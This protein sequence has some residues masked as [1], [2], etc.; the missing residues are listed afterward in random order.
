MGSGSSNNLDNKR[1][2]DLSLPYKGIGY[3][4][5]SGNLIWIQ[6][7]S[8]VAFASFRLLIP[9]KLTKPWQPTTTHQVSIL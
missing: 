5:S 9:F 8:K 4:G 1:Q 6:D 2:G 3:I 7:M